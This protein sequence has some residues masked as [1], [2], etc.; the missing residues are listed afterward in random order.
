MS[1][2]NITNAALSRLTQNN[3]GS[4]NSSTDF[5]VS[6]MYDIK[7]KFRRELSKYNIKELQ[8]ILKIIENI[9][10]NPNDIKF[11]KIAHRKLVLNVSDF[12]LSVG[13][14]SKVID[15]ELKYVFESIDTNLLKIGCELV[16]AAI[17]NI[18]KANQ[19]KMNDAKKYKEEQD[20]KQV[21]LETIKLEMIS[22]TK[23]F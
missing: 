3:L 8:F 4:L 5:T 13:F 23:D 2:E 14:T 19:E 9:L 6:E 12:L 20:R 15:F 10:Q 22:R 21:L 18:N 7:K 16:K 17:Y 1:K 11:R